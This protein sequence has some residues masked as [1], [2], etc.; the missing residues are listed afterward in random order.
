MTKI[1]VQKGSFFPLKW[2]REP[3]QANAK[4]LMEKKKK[5]KAQVA[6]KTTEREARALLALANMQIYY[7]TSITKT[8][9]H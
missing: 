5:K 3:G 6:W 8:G 4:A 2:S 7:E 1:K 9:G